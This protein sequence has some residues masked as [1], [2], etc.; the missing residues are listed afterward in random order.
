[1]FPRRRVRVHLHIALF[2]TFAM[3]GLHGAILRDNQQET[4]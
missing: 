4:A 2:S 1:M 3:V